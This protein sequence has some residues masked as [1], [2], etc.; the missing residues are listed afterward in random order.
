MRHLRR[1]LP[2]LRDALAITI[3]VAVCILLIVSTARAQEVTV[4]NHWHT[5]ST[6]WH[7]TTVDVRPPHAAG[8]LPDGTR[9]VVGRQTGRDVWA[10]DLHLE[11]EPRE[12]RTLNL[13]TGTA[14]APPAV[15]PP[16][17]IFGH[18]GGWAAVN[19]VPLGI[20][21]GQV[22]GAAVA[23]HLR[24]RI[25]R[26]F[27]V[28]AW[29]DWRP[30]EPWLV[31]GEAL[32]TSS[33]PAVPD[34]L[35]TV[36][37]GGY[38]LTFGDG[39]AWGNVLAPAGD[40]FA[41][42]QARAV[43]VAFAWPRHAPSYNAWFLTVPQ[44]V[45]RCVCLVGVRELWAGQG[46]PRVLP[47][48]NPGAWSGVRYP[49]ALSRIGT[50][51]AAV[52]GPNMNSADSGAQGDQVF[53]AGECMLQPGSE[54]V[55]Y[56]S[57]LKLAA[58]PN[59]LR[60]PDGSPMDPAEVATVQFWHGRPHAQ[61]THNL[62]GKSRGIEAVDAHGWW[63][64][65]TEHW[66][67]NGLT[68]AARVTGS[69]AL[70]AELSQQA[71][72]Y[73][74]SQALPGPGHENWVTAGTDA[75]RAIGWVNILAVH[76]WEN[77]E[78]RALAARVRQ[79][80]IDR[81]QQ[82]YIPQLG[83]RGDYWD[84]RRDD[85]RLGTGDWWIPWQ[86]S[87]GAYGLDLAGERFGV[88]EA[89][90]VALRG[91]RAVLRDA[92]R[93]D[94][95]RW[96]TQPQRPVDTTRDTLRDESFNYF[97]MSLAVATVLKHEPAN[98]TA[99]SI[100]QQ[101]LTSAT[102]DGDVSWL[103]PEVVL[104]P[105][106]PPA[107]VAT[108]VS[109]LGVTWT[110]ASPRPVGQFCT[111]EPWVVG[112]VTITGITPGLQTANGRTTGGSMLNPDPMANL[113]SDGSGRP[114]GKQGYD[115]KLF[116]PYLG[117]EN[118]SPRW[119]PS[120]SLQLPATITTG[121]IVSTVPQFGPAGDQ[122]SVLK[123]AAV[124]TVLSAVPPADAFRPPYA[125]TDKTIPATAA[126]IDWTVL[127]SLAPAPGMPD[128]DALLARFKGSLWL[129]HFP[130]WT[131]RYMHPVDGLP[132]YYRGFTTAIGNAALYA[133]STASQAQRKP[134]VVALAQ[135]GIDNHAHMKLG[136]I[137]GVNGHCN[138]RK[139]P[140][141][142]AGKVLGDAGMLAAGVTWQPTQGSRTGEAIDATQ[143]V[144]VPF[145]E[146]G[147]TFYVRET[148]PGVINWGFG[149]YTAA[150]VGLP[151]WGNFHLGN[152]SGDYVAWHREGQN[153][154]RRCCSA[155]SWSGVTLAMRAMGL[156]AAWNQPA[157]FDYVDRY[158]QTETTDLRGDAWQVAMWD[159]HRGAL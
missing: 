65:D 109:H 143:P 17:D 138:G 92:W 83:S 51:E 7:R 42:G 70:Q 40:T 154:Y 28:D 29:L 43:P 128:M 99:R 11:L 155:I 114:S 103:A 101:L 31:T 100:W 57:A 71:R 62:L 5:A 142:F 105:I 64:P 115:S 63:G 3:I 13:A 69:R 44:A 1:R 22:D 21:S 112:P 49:V 26:T 46:N 139:F 148:S 137:W 80:A 124:L 144:R 82:V 8:T 27:V 72:L 16:E 122:V 85:P 33:N 14:S 47:G 111:G 106:E 15:A 84:V 10:V 98:A 73:L 76:L 134:F 119:A 24:G 96:L 25:G 74:M 149:G 78:D 102:K 54:Q 77:L 53:V 89:R 67:A 136:A 107:P 117:D 146:D 150:H 23:V 4:A 50:W 126:D 158:L 37:A 116:D 2:D 133:N 81:M 141:L 60:R 94:A 38:A 48:L 35:E 59:H 157:F 104:Q 131:S 79:R 19:G 130:S 121:S 129:D 56:L 45:Y 55:A 34:V 86:Q 120:L 87:V 153:N 20:V 159:M 135:M 61:S 152:P 68:V 140:I 6:G 30:D 75:A 32:L 132:D 41:D 147:Q 58:R 108:T 90:N 125:G 156:R 113:L 36:P 93:Q 9:Y 151:E 127:A 52:T 91:A 97:G 95:G 12:V 88:P 123:T 118:G 145:S 66:L 110:F 39:L 18:F